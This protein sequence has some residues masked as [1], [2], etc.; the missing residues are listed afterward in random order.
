MKDFVSR[1]RPP[2]MNVENGQGLLFTTWG[3]KIFKGARPK[4]KLR[5]NSKRAKLIRPESRKN[6]PSSLSKYT[7]Q[8]KKAAGR[9]V[10]RTA[11]KFEEH[12]KK[13]RGLAGLL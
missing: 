1:N 11:K 13:A 9:H 5:G 8:K 3:G 2:S 12:K 4:R 7:N 10:L 6:P